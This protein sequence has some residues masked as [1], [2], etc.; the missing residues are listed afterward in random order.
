MCDYRPAYGELFRDYIKGYDFWGWS[1]M[2]LFYGDIRSFLTDDVLEYN[3]RVLTRGHLS[4]FKNNSTV[5]SYYRTL[6]NHACKNY[7][8]VYQHEENFAFDEW[9]NHT[10][11]FLKFLK[12]MESQCMTA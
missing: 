2:D 11:G 8:D 3:D 4:F 12:R 9:S 7:R 5:N 10:G 6:D 1:D